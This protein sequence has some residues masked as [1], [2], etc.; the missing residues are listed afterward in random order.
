MLVVAMMAT[1]S[2]AG[3]QDPNYVM[4]YPHETG[5]LPD[6]PGVHNG[7]KAPLYWSV[8]EYCY[9]EEQNG[10]TPIDITASHWD[11]I[12]EFVSRDLRPYGYDMVCTDGFCAMLT[13]EADGVY[14]DT[15]GSV[16]LTDLIAKCKAKGLR[17]G[18]Y[19][20][21]L[22]IHC[23]NERLIPGTDITVGS[24]RYNPS[25][26]A[27]RKQVLHPNFNNEGFWW[28]IAEHEG[29]K[30]YIDGFFKYYKELG[31]DYIRMDF[32]SWYEDGKD[33]NL[34]L[35]GKGY[36]SRSYALALRYIAEAATKYGVF[37]SIVMPHLYNDA[38]VESKYCNMT[39]VVCDAGYGGW[40]HTSDWQR[41]KVVNQ[42]PHAWNQFDGFTKWSHISGR[43]RILMDGDFLAIHNYSTDAEREFAVSLPLMA[44]S[45][46]TPTD[47][48]TTIG[49]YVKFYQN[50][51]MLA[52]NKDGF[53]G[54]PM[55]DIINSEGS[56]I[57]YGQMSNGDYVI[58]FFNREDKPLTRSVRFADLK[59]EGNYKVRDL[60]RHEDLGSADSFSANLPA[61]GC[62]II[63]LTK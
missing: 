40:G 2:M 59:I 36:G 10:R 33:N 16:K 58:G 28:L 35:V 20:N 60:W 41:G 5:D 54:H 62:Q 9:N 8:Y 31:V 22:W 42:W 12:I 53:V 11:E 61:H 57:W 13:T 24:L 23:P 21:P 52:L 7:Q 3:C 29:A 48:P 1:L 32:M 27:D 17:L 46:L 50:E 47:Q 4:H 26:E 19:D 45:T 49:S 51:E 56:N 39:R 37:T 6:V 34:G 25:S 30:E 43:N 18:V 44:G 63:R 15:Y 14:M 38:K 55:S